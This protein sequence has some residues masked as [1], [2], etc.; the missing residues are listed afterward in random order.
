MRKYVSNFANYKKLNLKDK[1]ENEESDDDKFED[2]N[3]AKYLS[4]E[5]SNKNI[6]DEDEKEVDFDMMR[7]KTIINTIY[8]TMK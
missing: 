2:E 8:N 5:F 4:K 6:N 3:I 7:A 1:D